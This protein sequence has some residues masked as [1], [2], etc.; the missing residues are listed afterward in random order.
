MPMIEFPE[1]WAWDDQDLM[2]DTEA[3]QIAARHAEVMKNQV[4]SMDPDYLM[5]LATSDSVHMKENS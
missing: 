1:T 4:E 3:E 2:Y 5:A